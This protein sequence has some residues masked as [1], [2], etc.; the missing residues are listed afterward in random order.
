MVIFH[1]YVSLP[2]GMYYMVGGWAY[3]SGKY[4]FVSWDD[5]IPNIMKKSHVPNHQPVYVLLEFPF[6]WTNP[7]VSMC[8]FSTLTKTW[9]APDFSQWDKGKVL[10]NRVKAHVHP[11]SIIINDSMCRMNVNLSI[12]LNCRTQQ[13]DL[14][15]GHVGPFQ[16]F[17]VLFSCT[18]PW[19]HRCLLGSLWL[20]E[21]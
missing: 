17:S 3:P 9:R 12:W 20:V 5:D 4:D 13:P 1:S 19:W 11:F 2:E 15:C 14:F 10:I 8:M 7:C 21:H 6:S 18:L 16:G